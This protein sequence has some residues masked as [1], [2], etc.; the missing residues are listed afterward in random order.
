M[1]AGVVGKEGTTAVA[2]GMETVGLVA[3]GAA[4]RVV[5]GG[6]CGSRGNE[7]VAK[8]AKAADGRVEGAVRAGGVG[9]NAAKKE[10]AGGAKA[11]AMGMETAAVMAAEAKAAVEEAVEKAVEKAEAAM[12]AAVTAEEKAE[13]VAVVMAAAEARGEA[14]EV[15]AE[16]AVVS[17]AAEAVPQA[18]GMEDAC[19]VERVAVL[20]TAVVR[21]REGM[22]RTRRSIFDARLGRKRN[23]PACF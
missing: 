12:A 20:D 15:A 6:T 17:A 9:A 18:E 10:V 23:S 7:G 2:E 11:V 19:L 21:A 22:C 8:V 1:G 3:V 13:E 14:V 5:A 4:V 16:L